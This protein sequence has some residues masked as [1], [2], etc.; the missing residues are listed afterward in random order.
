LTASV[1]ITGINNKTEELT[2]KPNEPLYLKNNWIKELQIQLSNV[3]TNAKINIT[4]N[5]YTE[6]VDKQIDNSLLTLNNKN[7]DFH[8]SF[9][10]IIISSFSWK[11]I[12]GIMMKVFWFFQLLIIIGIIYYN[13]FSTDREIFEKRLKYSNIFLVILIIT[14]G[15]FIIILATYYTYPN[16][17]D[18][19]NAITSNNNKNS[20]S[21]AFSYL[22]LDTRFATNLLYSFSPIKFWGVE[23]YK[24]SAIVYL[25]LITFSI[26]LLLKQIFGNYFK[27]FQIV[28]A[29]CAFSLIHF[30]M[31]PDITYELY[32]MASSSVYLVSWIS[33]FMWVAL[34]IKWINTESYGSKSIFGIFT[35][36]VF[37]LSFGFNEMN[38]VINT[39]ILALLSYYVLKY[40]KQFKNEM[41]I[42]YV[43]FIGICLFVFMIPGSNTRIGISGINTNLKSIIDSIKISG[44]AITKTIFQWSFTNA[45]YIPCIILSTLILNKI[46]IKKE[47]APFTTKE[48]SIFLLLSIL[49]IYAGYT[50]FLFFSTYYRT[51]II[52]FRA[53]NY[54]NWGYQIIVLI[55]LPIL[56]SRIMSSVLKKLL[57][58]FQKISFILI[59]IISIFVISGEN[60]LNKIFGEYYSGD[61][62]FFK[63]QMRKRY[64]TIYE[65]EKNEIWKLAIVDE[66][67]NIPRTIYAVPDLGYENE[68]MENNINYSAYYTRFFDIDE[69]RLV[70]DTTTIL[71]KLLDYE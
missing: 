63:E 59:I 31:I 41:L 56:L 52:V 66:L 10:Q 25:F 45:V 36:I 38:F 69:I 43:L 21:T 16:A 34:V 42:L 11:G 15:Y 35:L 60:N 50:F 8:G 20:L 62:S 17:E 47:I 24:I 44:I 32:Y 29:A 22:S 68:K 13:C 49:I 46:S 55:I 61:Y 40:K 4:T 37:L 14:I 30:A 1:K 54:I 58:H 39:F 3:N 70:N 28:I 67:I 64:E 19:S 65:A 57:P 18:L 6:I 48:I 71:D 23:S 12:S 26:F 7:T 51:D 33:I 53:L 9:L 2:L 27:T 5:N